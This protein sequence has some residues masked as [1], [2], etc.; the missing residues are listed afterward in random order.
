MSFFNVI[1]KPLDEKDNPQVVSDAQTVINELFSPDGAKR[2]PLIALHFAAYSDGTGPCLMHA[3]SDDFFRCRKAQFIEK[4]TRL[5]AAMA[6]CGA[7]EGQ[8]I[9]DLHVTC[10]REGHDVVSLWIRSDRDAPTAGISFWQDVGPLARR[11]T[12]SWDK[13]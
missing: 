12:I 1:Y 3:P 10:H 8:T 6:N 7:R 4:L 13:R 2:V 5:F 9:T 11:L